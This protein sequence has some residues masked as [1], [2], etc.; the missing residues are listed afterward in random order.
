MVRV[1]YLF[2]VGNF[3]F[4]LEFLFDFWK[5][6][7]VMST[8]ESLFPYQRPILPYLLRDTVTDLMIKFG[9]PYQEPILSYLGL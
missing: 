8:V 2:L 9:F 3:R 1:S 5:N 6:N 7:L 4:I